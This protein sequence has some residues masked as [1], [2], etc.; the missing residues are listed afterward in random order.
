MITLEE[1]ILGYKRN[2]EQRSQVVKC[3][4]IYLPD[5]LWSDLVTKICLLLVQANSIIKEMEIIVNTK[6]G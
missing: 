1:L 2:M 3:E 6:S 4:S 5:F